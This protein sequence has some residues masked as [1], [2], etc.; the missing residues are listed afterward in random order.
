MSLTPREVL[1]LLL[2]A[3]C[4]LNE[5]QGEL[6]PRRAL[7]LLHALRQAGMMTEAERKKFVKDF[8]LMGLLVKEADTIRYNRG[9]KPRKPELNRRAGTSEQHLIVLVTPAKQLDYTL[10]LGGKGYF[11]LL[12][13]KGEDYGRALEGQYA[14]KLTKRDFVK[15][16]NTARLSISQQMGAISRQE[17]GRQS[18]GLPPTTSGRT[19]PAAPVSAED[20]EW[21]N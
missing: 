1:D 4:W 13:E 6:K 7:M 10:L 8:K 9:Q 14:S 21:G 17:S 3:H 2:L 12:T 16:Y 18:Q 20:W 19:I 5:E 11:M 15:A